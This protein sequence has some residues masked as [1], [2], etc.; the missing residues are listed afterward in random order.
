[1]GTDLTDLATDIKATGGDIATDAQ[2]PLV[3]RG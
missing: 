2:R 3:T 1:M